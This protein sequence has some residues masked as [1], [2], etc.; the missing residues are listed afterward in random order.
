MA[1]DFLPPPDQGDED[2]FCRK[3]RNVFDVLEAS[4]LPRL[5]RVARAFGLLGLEGAS[6]ALAVWGFALRSSLPDFERKN[7]LPDGERHFG[8][9]TVFVVGLLLAGPVALFVRRVRPDL[10]TLER[11]SRRLCPLLVVGLIPFLFC[12]R[13]WVDWDIV[14]LPLVAVFSWGLSRGVRVALETNRTFPAASFSTARLRGW[15]T[16]LAAHA[17]RL[18]R[19]PPVAVVAVAATAYGVYFS[20]IS[21]VHHWNLGSSSFDLGLEDNLLWHVVHGGLPLFHSTPFGGPKVT[22]FGNHATFFA[23]VLAP[24]YAVAQRPETLLVVQAFLM[25][26]AAI[27]LYLFA[28]R[29]LPPWTAVIVALA[30]LVY[31]PLHGA[32]L[33]D[34]HYLPLGVFFLWLVLYAVETD[35]RPLA[36]L[37]IVLALSVRED[38]AAC[39]AV[40]GLFLLLRGTAPRAGALIAAIGATY[41]FVLKMAI[42]PIFSGGDPSFLNQYAGLLPEGRHGYAGVLETVLSNP[43]FTTKVLL[44]KEKVTYLLEIFTPLCFLPLRRPIAFLLVLPGFLFTLLATDYAPLNLPSFQYTSYW[45]AFMFLGVVIALEHAAAPRDSADRGGGIRQRALV[46]GLVAASVTCT[47]LDGAILNRIDV[48]WGFGRFDVATSSVDLEKRANLAALLAWIPKD[49]KVVASEH[50]VPHVS[51]RDT[52]YSLR[53]ALFD[54]DWLLFETPLNDGERDRAVDALTN[55]GFGVVAVQGTM[56]VAKRGAPN[57]LNPAVLSHL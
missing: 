43:V 4:P 3:V 48:R 49:A 23:Y 11:L 45:T 35:R 34:F 40:L 15:R 57:D 24:F 21:I 30:Y 26:A 18:P 42:M 6:A 29:H 14:A 39:L 2:G 12:R 22:H 13:V 17:K 27:P 25:G 38:V 20:V 54:A 37:S 51:N 50:L 55:G 56:A 53:H 32:N 7:L 46:V 41:F 8:L 16:E 44:T 52:A 31:P 10:E 36:V 33:Y 1:P 5:T 9:T 47:Y 28:S 19:I